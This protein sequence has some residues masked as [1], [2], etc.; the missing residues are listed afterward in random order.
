MASTTRTA[1][2]A[3]EIR[4]TVPAPRERVF[5]AWTRPEEVRRWSAPGP[6]SVAVAEIDLTVG[7]RYRIEMQAPDGARHVV[8]GTYRE[9][10]PP[11]RLV[12]NWTWEDQ[13]ETRDS[14]VTVEFHERGT[15]TEIVLRHE[16][17][18]SDESRVRH[19]HGWT[20]C[21]DNLVGLWSER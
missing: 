13:P 15:S 6:M 5:D 7:G 2:P 18:P 12:Y 16:R 3:L 8:G 17:L 19:E 21:L 10:D 1:T 20:G 11:R 14:L 9:I 4:R